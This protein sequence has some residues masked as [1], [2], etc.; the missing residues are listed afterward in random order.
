M[1]KRV[2]ILGM[3]MTGNEY[4]NS[5]RNMGRDAEGK[6][7]P[8]THSGPLMGE[9]WG[10]NLMGIVAACD[11]VIQL[12][13]PKRWPSIYSSWNTERFKRLNIPIVST[14]KDPLFPQIV[15]YPLKQILQMVPVTYINNSVAGA[16]A[17]A[18]L[19][20]FTEIALFG[21]DFSYADPALAQYTE[22]GRACVEFWIA[23][24][25]SRGIHV[26]VPQ[27]GTLLDAAHGQEIYGYFR[28]GADL[29]RELFQQPDQVTESIEDLRARL[30]V[31]EASQNSNVVPMEAAE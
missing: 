15:E 20:G 25:M 24:A 7:L 22:R 16:I 19:E 21:C 13:D 31:A 30:A 6:D 23:L 4:F 10:I 3:G 1:G 12:N 27:S 28:P 9:I 26:T 5:A 18:M 2:T 29:M 11:R 8:P 17:L 14:S